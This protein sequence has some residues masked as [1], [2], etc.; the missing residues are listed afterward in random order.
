[1][2]AFL[3]CLVVVWEP[4]HW[5]LLL[6]AFWRFPQIT[7]GRDVS[8]CVLWNWETLNKTLVTALFS[9]HTDLIEFVPQRDGVCLGLPQGRRTRVLA[10]YLAWQ[11][12][13]VRDNARV[14]LRCLSETLPSLVTLQLKRLVLPKCGAKSAF[15]STGL[16]GFELAT[17]FAPS[18]LAC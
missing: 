5:A 18:A 6:G 3:S 1:M 7:Q 17:R 9:S 2:G 10:R 11:R 4:L 13:W 12:P 15:L 8:P 16:L 14:V